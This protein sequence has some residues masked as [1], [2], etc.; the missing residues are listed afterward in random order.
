MYIIGYV[1]RSFDARAKYNPILNQRKQ[2]KGIYEVIIIYCSAEN[3]KC[4][5]PLLHRGV[6]PGGRGGGEGPSPSPPPPPNE[7]IGGQTYRFVPP[8]Q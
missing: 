4:V 8:P 5:T 6:G 2:S 7:N 1:V 3:S